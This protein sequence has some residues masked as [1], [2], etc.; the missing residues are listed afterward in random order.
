MPIV[1]D[2]PKQATFTLEQKKHAEYLKIRKRLPWFVN[3]ELPDKLHPDVN[4]LKTSK[5]F[6]IHV[7]EFN[8]IRKILQ[9]IYHGHGMRVRRRRYD[10]FLWGMALSVKSGWAIAEI[11]TWELWSK[12]SPKEYW[13][14]VVVGFIGENYSPS[15]LMGFGLG[16]LTLG[17]IVAP[18]TFWNMNIYEWF[19][20]K[21]TMASEI[22][23]CNWDKI[24]KD[25]NENGY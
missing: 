23:L 7:W 13:R 5:K 3:H 8:K 21:N 11:P 9:R 24:L 15:D 25:L 14:K 4:V 16:S 10:T 18:N 22:I 6:N 2:I 20:Y 12:D 19:A 1:E 17:D